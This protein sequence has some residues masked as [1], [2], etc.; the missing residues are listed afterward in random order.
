MPQIEIYL[1]RIYIRSE[2]SERE[3]IKQV[4]GSR[5]DKD[6]SMWHVP[7]AW[8]SCVALRSIFG[9]HLT[10]GTE[11]REWAKA[12]RAEKIDPA[13]ALRPAME[14][15]ELMAAEPALDPF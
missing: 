15:P 12:L 13:L 6:Q 7:L 11:L 14:A 10:M 3:L 1:E 2:L 8:G 9:Q 5:W 4:P